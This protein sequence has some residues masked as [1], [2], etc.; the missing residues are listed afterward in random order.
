LQWGETYLCDSLSPDRRERMRLKEEILELTLK[1]QR[2]LS[3][4]EGERRESERLR[5]RWKIRSDFICERK[6]DGM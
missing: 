4:H 2:K 6:C 3:K 1:R 5:K